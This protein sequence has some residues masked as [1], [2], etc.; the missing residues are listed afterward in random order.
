MRSNEK[1]NC[2]IAG[3]EVTDYKHQLTAP[4][5]DTA[6]NE[7]SA[8][9]WKSALGETDLDSK[10]TKDISPVLI[11]A[12]IKQPVFM[13]A[14]IDDIRAPLG[15]IFR[16]KTELESAGNP[17]KGYVLK[18]DERHGFGKLENR[19]DLYNQILVFPKDQFDR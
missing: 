6:L 10:T 19:V 13:Y 1:W 2:A 4:E 8:T 18:E 16:M 3:L 12:K 11:A 17:G 9:F 7:A 14:G 15:Q 5:G